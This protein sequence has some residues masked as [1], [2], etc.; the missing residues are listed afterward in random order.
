MCK[1]SEGY[2]VFDKKKFC[3]ECLREIVE[4]WRSFPNDGT[5][6]GAGLAKTIGDGKFKCKA[7]NA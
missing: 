1:K 5:L 2:L 6:H 3:Y 4:K 7:Y